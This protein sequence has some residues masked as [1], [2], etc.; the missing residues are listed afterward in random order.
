MGIEQ[1]EKNFC[2]FEKIGE[3]NFDEIVFPQFGMVVGSTEYFKT[4]ISVKELNEAINDNVN[5]VFISKK[6]FHESILDMGIFFHHLLSTCCNL[7]KFKNSLYFFLI[8]C[9]TKLII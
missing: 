3:T 4:K 2:I 7:I 6:I 8:R 9:N 1:Y 5:D